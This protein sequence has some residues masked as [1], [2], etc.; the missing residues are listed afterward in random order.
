MAST[1]ILSRFFKEKLDRSKEEISETWLT[2]ED[3]GYK[4]ASRLN[5]NLMAFKG[6]L[7]LVKEHFLHSKRNDLDKI[8]QDKKNAQAKINSIDIDIEKQ[9]QLIDKGNK[10]I[11]EL[12][13]KIAEHRDEI[14][15]IKENP[16]IVT[17]DKTS[18]VGFIIGLVILLVL[19]V[20]LFVFYSSAAYSALFKDFSLDSLGLADSIFD[21]QALPNALKEGIF[22]LILLLTIPSV[23]LGLGYLIHK[24]QE[25]EGISKYLKVGFLIFITFIFDAFLAFDITEKIHDILQKD[26]FGEQ[27]DYSFSLAF[28]SPKFW[29]IIFLGFVVYI[30]WG[31]VFDF[32]MEAYDKLDVVKQAINAQKTNVKHKEETIAKIK[33]EQEVSVHNISEFRKDKVELQK[34]VD[35]EIIKYNWKGLEKELHNYTNGWTHWMTENGLTK[36]HIDQT[37]E[38]LN[39]F[40]TFNNNPQIE[41]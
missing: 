36:T 4:R 37:W 7:N 3:W 34:I 1:N 29:T 30:I 26:K 5:G 27:I 39:A 41:L 19:T 24:F 25:Q 13:Q 31:L 21:P 11:D 2:Y 6:C 17:K 20:Y 18:K 10:D 35:G 8:E 40:S 28:E 12:N 22:E 14:I 33:K 23:F 32:I 38:A 15:K 16:E 9:E